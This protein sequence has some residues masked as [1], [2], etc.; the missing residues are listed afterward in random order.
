MV[1][2]VRRRRP[3][4]AVRAGRDF[5]LGKH[6]LPLLHRA[7]ACFGLPVRIVT[8]ALGIL[9]QPAAGA[10]AIQLP[11]GQVAH[12]Q[13]I[14]I[15]VADQ[16]FVGFLWSSAYRG[17]TR[18][19]PTMRFALS[20]EYPCHRGQAGTGAAWNALGATARAALA[21]GCG[22]AV[23]PGLAARTLPRKESAGSP[24]TAW[25]QAG[26]VSTLRGTRAGGASGSVPRPRALSIWGLGWATASGMANSCGRW[27][28]E[29]IPGLAP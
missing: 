10:Q 4:A 29:N 27:R 19:N 14:V 11:E 24:S 2:P 7:A 1:R 18:S 12:E 21:G 20:L 8:D 5:A 17:Y 9:R 23:P 6:L 28:A 26:H 3:A 22:R 15:Q 16:L 13:V 25:R